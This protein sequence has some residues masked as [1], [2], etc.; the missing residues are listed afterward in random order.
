[1][2]KNI[3]EQLLTCF[4]TNIRDNP[5]G[6][7]LPQGVPGRKP[8]SDDMKVRLASAPTPT[9]SRSETETDE[10]AVPN[11]RGM[12]IRE[13]VNK[14]KEKGIEVR[15]I[16]SGWAIAQQPAAGMPTPNGRLCTV[17]FGMGS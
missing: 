14:S 1:V 17:T 15:I 8:V 5:I 12:T 13:V 9:L 2:F 16:G 4:K 3:G 7:T 10:T 6:D 11:F